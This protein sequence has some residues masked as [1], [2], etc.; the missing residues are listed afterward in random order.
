MKPKIELQRNIELDNGLTV[1][2]R[3]LKR[4]E[5]GSFIFHSQNR[6]AL[7]SYI[8]GKLH[9]E[10]LIDYCIVPIFGDIIPDRVVANHLEDLI[11]Y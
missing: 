3:V 4:F 9:T 7:N 11:N 8:N 5:D 6:V 2:G 10:V 1:K